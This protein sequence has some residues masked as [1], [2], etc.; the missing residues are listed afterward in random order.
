MAR[1]NG[2]THIVWT[3]REEKMSGKKTSAAPL[4]W[5]VVFRGKTATVYA[6]PTLPRP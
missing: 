5:P 2:I 4:H 6:A 3:E 1:E